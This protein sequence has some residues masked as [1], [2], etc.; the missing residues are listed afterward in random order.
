[1]KP[2]L[3]GLGNRAKVCET[4][5]GIR[6]V[7]HLQGFLTSKIDRMGNKTSRKKALWVKCKKLPVLGVLSF[8]QA[9]A[10]TKVKGCRTKLQFQRGRLTREQM[11]HLPL[12]QIAL[13]VWFKKLF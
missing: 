8:S 3:L 10:T 4:S 7:E 12:H 5:P 9:I 13:W 11:H 1:V 2:C 6:E